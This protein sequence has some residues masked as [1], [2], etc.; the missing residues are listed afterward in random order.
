MKENSQERKAL[1]SQGRKFV[2]R[3]TARDSIEIIDSRSIRFS[4]EMGP[5][6]YV[7]TFFLCF[8]CYFFCYAQP[9]SVLLL[10]TGN[11]KCK[12]ILF[13]NYPRLKYI[14][15]ILP[16]YSRAIVVTINRRRINNRQAI[17][18]VVIIIEKKEKKKEKRKKKK[19]RKHNISYMQ[20]RRSFAVKSYW[21]SFSLFAKRTPSI[22]LRHRNFFFF[23]LYFSHRSR[24]SYVFLI[25]TVTFFFSSS[26]LEQDIK[27]AGETAGSTRET[28]S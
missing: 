5:P 9:T 19:K 12:L 8:F 13:F 25:R 16:P 3:A 1:S 2:F 23:S 24:Y 6:C 11:C 10:V 22:N 27:H 18:V 20:Y 4:I 14:L 26:S 28:E 21:F 7:Y 17:V 15:Y